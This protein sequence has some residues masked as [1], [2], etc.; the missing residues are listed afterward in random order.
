MFAYFNAC[1]VCLARAGKWA[2]LVLLLGGLLV[3]GQ[4][5]DLALAAAKETKAEPLPDLTLS[6]NPMLLLDVDT[7]NV[8]YQQEANRKWYPAS[9]TKLMTAYI[10]FRALESGELSEDSVLTVSEHALAYPPAKM[11]FPVGTQLTVANA[12][13]MVL[14]KSAND[15]AAALG[16]RISGSEA[17]FANRMNA[18][19]ARLGM[20]ATHFVNANGLYDRRQTSSARDL[21]LLARHI[22]LEFPQY[23]FLFQIPA[24]RHGKR[25]LRSYNTLLEQ[26]RGSNGMKTGFVCAS[27]YNIVA[28]AK[29]GGRQLIAVVL[30][31]PNS[32]IRAETAAFLLTQG[33]SRKDMARGTGVSVANGAAFGPVR[34]AKDLRS[35]I[36]P[37]GQVKWT[38]TVTFKNSYLSPRFKLMDP[39]RVYVGVQKTLKPVLLP[40][41]LAQLPQLGPK[42]KS[43]LPLKAQKGTLIHLAQLPKPKP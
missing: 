42:A 9:L 31:A 30:G 25:V 39:V 7:G 35:D 3:V 8:L 34:S 10:A 43:V 11:G 18:E 41:T 17:A 4:G 19:A 2:V 37:N 23:R 12:L 33:F 36:C 29:R 6:P 15:I 20:S 16:E 14:V 5:A 26:F 40:D 32:Q 28:S 1:L 27:G 22:L 38:P 21:A 13:R 24:I